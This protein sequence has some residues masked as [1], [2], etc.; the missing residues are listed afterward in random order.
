MFFKDEYSTDNYDWM[1]SM[2]IKDRID[3]NGMEFGAPVK[4]AK[5]LK[6]EDFVP[7]ENEK[8]YVFQSLIHY[9]SHRLMYRHPESFSS[10]KSCIRVN[11]P[12]QFEAEME[13]RSDEFTGEL[14]TKSEARTEDLI[15]MMVD[16]QAKY[17]HK[18]EDKEGNI[19]CYEKKILSGDN[20][21]EK[22]QTF[23]IYRFKCEIFPFS[24]LLVLKYLQYYSQ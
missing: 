13:R 15:D 16:I 11:Q 1:A 24:F 23:G 7:T 12:H 4:A 18:F 14:F 17:V 5:D 20:K 19:R 6:I 21:T 3:V 2:F 22:N 8:D 10:I 9:F